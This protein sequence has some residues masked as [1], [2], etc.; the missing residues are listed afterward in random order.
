M[1]DGV[2]RQTRT[3][4]RWLMADSASQNKQDFLR[5]GYRTFAISYQRLFPAISN[6]PSAL[7]P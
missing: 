4:R 6:K 2:W 1:A 3:K 7:C 5:L